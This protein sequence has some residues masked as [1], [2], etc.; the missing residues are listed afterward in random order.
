MLPPLHIYL[1]TL[2][3]RSAAD[4]GYTVCGPSRTSLLTG[5]HSG[6]FYAKGLTG[7]AFGP[8]KFVLTLPSML[9]QAGYATAAFG[10]SDPLL[11]PLQQ[12][13]EYFIGQVDQVECHDMYPRA[14]DFGAGRGNLNLSLNW[15]LDPKDPTGSRQAC[16]SRPNDFNYTQDITHS[17]AMGWLRVWADR[18]KADLDA[19]GRE[20]P[21]FLYQSYA[22]PHAGGWGTTDEDGAPVPHLG[23]YAAEDWPLVEKDHAAVVSYLDERVGDMMDL[24]TELKLES[25]TLT[26]F[27]SDN[28]PH[29]E[30]GHSPDFF[31]S[32]G[33]LRGAKR[34]LYE[35]GVRSPTMAHWPGTIPRGVSRYRW[36]L[37]AGARRTHSPP[38]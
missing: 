21:F 15:V 12:G 38:L 32:S 17:Y 27:A 26:I 2:C 23:R 34:S 20:R 16:M 29:L 28:G 14:I 9:K 33:G 5:Y 22:V 1:L 4:A 37:Y 25:R 10:K 6:N 31:G 30:G 13:F 8:E 19:D 36:A 3:S 11:A 7:T 18:S 24:L 35:G